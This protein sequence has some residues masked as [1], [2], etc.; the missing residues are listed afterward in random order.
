MNHPRTVKATIGMGRDRT[1]GISLMSTQR[2][3]PAL[4]RGALDRTNQLH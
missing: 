2:L 1:I 3:P 4:T